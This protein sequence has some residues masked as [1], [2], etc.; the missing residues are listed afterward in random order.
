MM[1]INKKNKKKIDAPEWDRT[2]DLQVNSLALYRLSYKSL[3]LIKLNLITKLSALII[4]SNY[5]MN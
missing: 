4:E 1:K 3:L 5:Q 2:T